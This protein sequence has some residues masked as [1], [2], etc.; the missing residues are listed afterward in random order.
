MRNCREWVFFEQC[1]KNCILWIRTSHRKFMRSEESLQIASFQPSIIYSLSCSFF[2]RSSYPSPS[3]PSQIKALRVF[4][5]FCHT[6]DH[7]GWIILSKNL[8]GHY[9][10]SANPNARNDS[11]CSGANRACLYR[12][13]K[14]IV[15][16]TLKV[17]PLIVVAPLWLKR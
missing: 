8:L 17:D 13:C 6:K 5:S 10:N 4:L 15:M 3:S 12:L 2:P 16:S 1:W 11:P 9:S 7:T 14:M